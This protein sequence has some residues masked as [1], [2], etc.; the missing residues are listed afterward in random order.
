MSLTREQALEETIGLWTQLAD[1]AALHIAAD[2]MEIG[3]P[4]VNYCFQCPCCEYLVE[5]SRLVSERSPDCTKFCPLE[6][7]WGYYLEEG[8][9]EKSFICTASGSPY[10]QWSDIVEAGEEGKGMLFYDLEFFCRL[11]AELAHE[12]LLDCLGHDKEGTDG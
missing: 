10:K 12:A 9:E 3:G 8:S 7:Q 2:K 6:K 11:V 5:V 4:W 1:K